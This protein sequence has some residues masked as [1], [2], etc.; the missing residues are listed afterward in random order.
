MSAPLHNSPKSH[1]QCFSELKWLSNLRMH[2]ILTRGKK[3]KPLGMAG[4][5]N[6]S[7]TP[8]AL[9]Y[10]APAMH[11]LACTMWG[12]LEDADV[13]GRHH[14]CPHG[15][16]ILGN[17]WTMT[18]RAFYTWEEV[19]LWKHG[20]QRK[21]RHLWVWVAQRKMNLGT[22]AFLECGQLYEPLNQALK[23]KYGWG[24]TLR[25]ARAIRGLWENIQDVTNSPVWLEL[26]RSVT[27]KQDTI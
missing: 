6:L 4:R 14:L 20:T 2:S 18:Q 1:L 10:L 27:E 25:R 5:G 7:F 21:E 16:H 15:V 23:N 3:Y 8:I 26:A 17:Y 19:P 22:L 11:H 12:T 9:Y 24:G 13:K